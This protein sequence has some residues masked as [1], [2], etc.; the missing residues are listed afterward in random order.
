MLKVKVGMTGIKGMLN[1][2]NMGKT[3]EKH[4]QKGSE[5]DITAE[6]KI[7]KMAELL[8][9]VSQKM[10]VQDVIDYSEAGAKTYVLKKADGSAAAWFRP[11]QYVSVRIKTEPETNYV[12]RPYSISSSPMETKD[13]LVKITVKKTSEGFVSNYILKHW[14]KGSEVEI[15]GPEGSFYYEKLRDHKNV[16]AVAGGSG[17]TPFLSMAK[18]ISEGIEDFNLTI[19]FGNRTKDSILFKNEFDEICSKTDKV[20]VIHV[21]S[22]EKDF[23]EDPMFETGFITSEIIKKYAENYSGDYSVFACGPSAMYSFLKGEIEKLG[24]ARKDVRFEIQ[25][26]LR[27]EGGK[28][29]SLTI[30]TLGSEKTVPVLAGETILSAIEKSGVKCTARCRGGE[31]GW[32]RSKLISGIIYI[33]EES[34]F[35]R[36]GDKRTNYIHP[37]VT[38]AESDVIIEVPAEK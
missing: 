20:R 6:Y 2:K 23:P 21:L 18:A 9:P 25:G 10:I 31:C 19:L 22:E 13:G 36:F 28:D 8:H 4:I 16:I 29:Y 26:A 12:T 14:E 35:R 38:F 32:C 11:G 1:F 7:N 37:C 33:P 30:R 27:L 24:L 5:N 34:E 15:S 17:I 3:R